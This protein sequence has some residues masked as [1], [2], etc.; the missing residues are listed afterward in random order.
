MIVSLL[1]LREFT[2]MLF[3][4]KSV[5]QSESVA[6]FHFHPQISPETSLYVIRKPGGGE[7]LWI[8]LGRGVPLRL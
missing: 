4:G 2:C 7:V 6:T 1:I 3:S 5:H 8:F